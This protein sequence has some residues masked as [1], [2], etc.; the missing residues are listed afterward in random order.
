GVTF[1]TGSLG[2]EPS[3][4]LPAMARR[5]GERKRIHFAHCR[6]VKWTGT[7]KFNEAPHPTRLGDVDMLGVLTALKETG[8][9]GPM[10]PDHGRMIWGETGRAGYGLYDRALGAKYL[11]G[12]WE[13]ISNAGS[14]SSVVTR[15]ARMSFRAELPM[16]FRAE[17]SV[18]F[19]AEPSV[20]FRAE[21]SVS[22]RAEP[23]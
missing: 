3:N 5:L 23:S 14:T 1:C 9:E 19:R 22:F 2:A 12:L 20:S 17:P 21:P 18:S 16:S 10:R 11:Y 4:D 8:F 13:G 7:K 15:T 6:N